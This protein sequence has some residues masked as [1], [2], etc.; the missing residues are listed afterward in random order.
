MFQTHQFDSGE[1]KN[2]N[3][4]IPVPI[5]IKGH[6]PQSFQGVPQTQTSLTMMPNVF[7]TPTVTLFT[8][9]LDLRMGMLSLQL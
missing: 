9:L 4:L 1:M 3:Y 7:K 8:Q 5:Q 6:D 2:L